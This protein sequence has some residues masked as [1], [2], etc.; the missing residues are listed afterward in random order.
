MTDSTE[1]PNRPINFRQRFYDGSIIRAVRQEHRLLRFPSPRLIDIGTGTGE[2]LIR[3]AEDNWFDDFQLVGTDNCPDMLEVAR[4]VVEQAGLANRITIENN[5][6]HSLPYENESCDYVT[7][8]S[9]V[10][11]WDNAVQALQEISR[12]LKPGGVA[13][14]HEPRRDVSPSTLVALKTRLAKK[15]LAMDSLNEKLTPGEMWD[16]LEEAG[17]APHSIINSPSSSTGFE[18]RIAKTPAPGMATAA[19][20]VRTSFKQ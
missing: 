12:V 10:Y 14:I 6:V 16:I 2:L 11:H 18:V 8:Q 20:V 9:T 7:A 3:L 1:E 13:I 5:D 4:D 19:P 15:G 17:L